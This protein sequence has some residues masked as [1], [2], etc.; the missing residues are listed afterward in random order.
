MAFI[1][2]KTWTVGEVL[3][4]VDMNVYVRDNTADLNDRMEAITEAFSYRFAGRRVIE[5]N[6]TFDKNDAF[7]D[8]TDTSW[9][10]RFKFTVVGGGGAGGGKITTSSGEVANGG[11]GAAGAYFE[12]FVDAADLGTSVSIT[13]G[14]GGTGASASAGGAGTSTIIDGVVE[15]EGGGGGSL[16]N[17]TS[18]F[19]GTSG[20]A[21]GLSSNNG[22]TVEAIVKDAFYF[23]G[24]DGHSA[25]GPAGG[26]G[27]E[28]PLG[29]VGRQGVG[30]TGGN[31][32]PSHGY[33]VGGSGCGSFSATAETGAAGRPGVV[34]V[35]IFR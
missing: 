6:T 16:S 3:S 28:G 31:A 1:S 35:D 32:A 12:G 13:I 33:G 4:A 24:A 11:G 34:I 18:T 7:G 29:S 22:V 25:Y 2:P 27:G 23:D 21:G 26:R 17:A 19:T 30:T 9:A 20:A 5:S 14:T 8:G 15:C 10:R